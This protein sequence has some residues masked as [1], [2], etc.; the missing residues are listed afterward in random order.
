[1]FICLL[2]SF[3]GLIEKSDVSSP[4]KFCQF[5]EASQNLWLPGNG[6]IFYF[7][8]LHLKSSTRSGMI[9]SHTASRSGGGNIVVLHYRCTANVYQYG[10]TLPSCSLFPS[11]IRWG[12]SSLLE[13]CTLKA[14]QILQKQSMADR[15]GPHTHTPQF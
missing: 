5:L 12:S 10:A 3:V 8:F 6:N 7:I 2:Q 13:C 4:N 14:L 15:D 1:M 11:W 9:I